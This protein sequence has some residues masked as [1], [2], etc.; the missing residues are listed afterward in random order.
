MRSPICQK[1]WPHI[2]KIFIYNYWYVP[3]RY[4]EINADKRG[5]PSREHNTKEVTAKYDSTTD[6]IWLRFTYSR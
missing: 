1:H 6:S 3:F 4:Q 5:V 2:T